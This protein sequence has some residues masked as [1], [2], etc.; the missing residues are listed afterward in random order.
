V[1]AVPWGDEIEHS[2]LQVG[3]SSLRGFT[4]PWFV[5]TAF[6]HKK[7]KTL[8]ITD[9]VLKVSEDPVPVAVG[10]ALLTLFCSRNTN[11]LQPVQS[12]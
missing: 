2:V 7:S 4:D 3:G 8:L 11:R 1:G 5:D 9:V 10:L 12:T 6:Y